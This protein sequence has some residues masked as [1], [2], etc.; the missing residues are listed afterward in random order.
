[1][2]ATGSLAEFA[3]YL[4]TA[5]E[6]D[7][8]DVIVMDL[9]LDGSAPSLA[10]ISDLASIARVLVISASGRAGDVLGAI[11]AGA[12]G[13]LT[14]QSTP[15]LLASAVTT[16]AAGGFSLSAELADIVQAALSDRPDHQ[17]KAALSP[18]EEQTLSLIARGLTHGQI[19][20]RLGVRK[21]TVDTYVE[22]IRAKLQ[23]GN[24]AELT[25]AA[26]SRLDPGAA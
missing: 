25:R 5:A 24:K 19:A 2:T 22:R 3:E 13:Y 6:V 26:L 20:T 10:E 8:P 18:R 4:S 21:A 16:L 12:S 14:K 9:Y 1:M 17:R 11:R 15:E 23:V 7:H